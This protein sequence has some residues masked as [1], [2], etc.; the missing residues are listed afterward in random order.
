MSSNDGAAQGPTSSITDGYQPRTGLP[1]PRRFW[2]AFSIWSAI[3]LT[4]MDVSIAN[5]ALPFIS[6]GLEVTAA[7]SVWAINA[8]QIAI[9]M[10]LLP[11]AKAAE[12]LGYKKVYLA[13][14][15]LFMLA[16]FGSISASSLPVLALA[17]FVQGIGAAAVMVV[18]GALVR[19]IY[20]PELVPRGIGYNTI[21]V[22]IASAAG[23]AVGALVLSI[24]GWHAVFAVG[25]PFGLLSLALGIWALPPNA[26]VKKPFDHTSALLCC[27][28]FAAIF[29]TLND[30][31]QNSASGWTLLEIGVAIPAIWFLSKR[32]SSSQ[33]SMVPLDLLKLGTL[34]AAYAMSVSAYIVMILITLSFPFI[35]QQRFHFKPEAIGLFMVPLPLGIVIAAFVSGRLVNRYSSAWLCASGLIILACGAIFLSLLQPNASAFLIIAVTALCGIGFGIF[36]VPNNHSMIANAPHSRTGAA[37]AMLSMSRLIGQTLGAL[38]AA[39]LFRRV[40]AQS[41]APIMAAAMIALM[42]ASATLLQ[43]GRSRSVT[44]DT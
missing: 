8:Y 35:L 33:D 10:A 5:V 43:R 13:G 36:Q 24:A 39:L 12:I 1:V 15:M 6:K 30:L 31:A 26:S 22:S 37:S 2:A 11:M 9:V 16:A 21:A 44:G 25:L 29:L 32:T 40:G 27:A 18:S 34:R 19:T 23:P 3:F 28:G 4:I 14:L 17:R 42:V 41:D 38:L 7:K 20:P